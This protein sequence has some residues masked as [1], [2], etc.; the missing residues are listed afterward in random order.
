MRSAFWKIRSGLQSLIEEE[1]GQDLVEY[2]LIIALLVI[3]TVTS[4]HSFSVALA[5]YFQYIITS[6]QNAV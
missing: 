3:A 2:S 5:N 6:F 4:V 1:E